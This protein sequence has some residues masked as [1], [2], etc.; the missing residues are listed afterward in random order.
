MRIVL[1]ADDF[2]WSNDTVDATIECI[3]RGAITSASIMAKMPG[4]DRAISYARL[5]PEVSWGVHLTWLSDGPEFPVSPPSEIPSL[6]TQSGRFIASNAARMGGLLGTLRQDDVERET[7]AQLALV[8]DAGVSLSHV[9]SHGHLHKFRTFRRALSGVLPRFGI[10]RVRSVQDVYLRPPLR[11]PTYWLGGVW[12][13]EIASRFLTTEHFYMPASQGDR[14]W[15]SA[16]LGKLG[17]ETLEVGVHPGRD[18]AWKDGERADTIAFSDI[19][20]A[21]GHTLIGWKDL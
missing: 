7:A 20:R 8:R 1:T 5:H 15:G 16:L 18:E 3:E 6:V 10:R 17:G 12:R 11:S 13:R 19:A 2:G 9:D 21:R 4:T 14:A